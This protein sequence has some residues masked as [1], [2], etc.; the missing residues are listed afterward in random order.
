MYSVAR[1]CVKIENTRQKMI[2]N[3]FHCAVL[4]A[5]SGKN[6]SLKK[7]VCLQKLY[8]RK[9]QLENS[10]IT[11]IRARRQLGLSNVHKGIN[12]QKQTATLGRCPC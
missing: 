1:I 4:Q 2:Q 6:A 10:E 9:K 8:W 7:K 12:D 11:K 5:L 3:C